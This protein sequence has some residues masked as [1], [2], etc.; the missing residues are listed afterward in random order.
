MLQYLGATVPLESGPQLASVLQYLGA[1]VPLESG[2]Q[3]M[4]LGCYTSV[5]ENFMESS[6][7]L[8]LYVTL[9][10]LLTRRE[11][12]RE[13]YGMREREEFYVYKIQPAQLS[14]FQS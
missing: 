14:N 8:K 9:S 7:A 3:P 5:N 12:R 1:T 10:I 11:E 13:F 2:P 6:I 4:G